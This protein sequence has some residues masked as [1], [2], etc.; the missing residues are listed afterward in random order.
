MSLDNTTSKLIN[1]PHIRVRLFLIPILL[2]SCI[3]FFGLRNLNGHISAVIMK[4][5]QHIPPKCRCL[6]IKLHGVTF[7]KYG[8]SHTSNHKSRSRRPNVDNWFYD[9][10]TVHRNRLLVNKTNRRTEF[11]FYCY[12]DSTCFGQPFC[13]SSGVLSLHQLWYILCSCDNRLLPGVGWNCK[14]VTS[15]SW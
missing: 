5:K 4:R 1:F 3:L 13:S 15:Y 2:F 6:I 8:C 11:H 12:Y 14:T 10:M 9:R 7:P